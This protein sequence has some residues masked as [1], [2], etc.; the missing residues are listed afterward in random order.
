MMRL[1]RRMTGASL[2]AA[3]VLAGRL[4]LGEVDGGV[5]ELGEHGVDRL[6]LGLAVVPVDRL[7]DLLLRGEDRRDLGVEDEL[8]LLHR[9][10][11]AGVAHDDLE[12]RPVG[13]VGQD[14]VL[15]GDRLGHLLDD[16]GG[17]GHVGQVDELDA[18]VLGDG[19]H[20]LL[21]GGVA[22]LDEG[23]GELG[24]GLLRDAARLLE[25][26]GA[27]D[28]LL[29]EDGRKSPRALAMCSHSRNRVKGVARWHP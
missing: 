15:A 4:G 19:A 10:Q 7:D 23:V 20:D 24:P 17:D 13:G 21:G 25:L 28:V 5:G 29:D 22:E 2:S 16:G 6:G 18:A 12:H 3:A 27:E 8:E 14:D 9:G 1:H 11:V 26:V